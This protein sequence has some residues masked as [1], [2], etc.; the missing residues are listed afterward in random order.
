MR[1][2]NQKT[3]SKWGLFTRKSENKL[4]FPL[5]MLWF[6]NQVV[7]MLL[8]F[9]NCLKISPW[10]RWWFTLL[11]ATLCEQ[12]FPRKYLACFFSLLR[13]QYFCREGN[14]HISVLRMPK[15]NDHKVEPAKQQQNA[16]QSKALLTFLRHYFSTN[17]QTKSWLPVKD[18]IENILD[19]SS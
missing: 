8:Q 16:R 6:I 12:M 5:V 18:Q 13:V 1:S 9:Q 10:K 11:K 3:F 17:K 7:V 19:F 15:P 14:S 2:M 4:S